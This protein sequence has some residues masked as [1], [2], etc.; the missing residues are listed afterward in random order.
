MPPRGGRGSAVDASTIRT[1]QAVAGAALLVVLILIVIGVHS[2]A[3]SSGNDALRSYN[4]N[5]YSLIRASNQTGQQFF[6]LMS[7]GAGSNPTTLYSKV[8]QT[9]RAANSQFKQAEGL[10]APSQLKGAQQNLVQAMRMRSDGIANVA[11]QLQ[12]ALQ[13]STASMALNKIAAQMAILYASDALYKAYVLPGIETALGNAGISVGG[14]NGVPVDNGQFVPNLQWLT[15]SYVAQGLHATLPT[16]PSKPAA[17]GI[18]GHALDSCSVGS[19]T[20][21]TTA[22]TTLPA[23]SAPTLSCTVTNDGQ[24]VETNVVVTASIQGTSIVGQKTIPQTQPGH[25]YPVQIPLSAAP[26]AGTYSLNVTVQHV[27]GET[28]FTHNTKIFPVTF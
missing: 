25:Q 8:E 14:S 6:R 13:T 3:V 4:D 21:S 7:A 22:A 20:L 1:R 5:V 18:H 17:P 9:R 26:P 24:N 10:S 23:G 11:G 2:S 19:A 28:T 27:P 12:A 15:P 16:N